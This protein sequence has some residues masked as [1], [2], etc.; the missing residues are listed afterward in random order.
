MQSAVLAGVSGNLYRLL[1]EY[2]VT[3]RRSR[4]LGSVFLLEID[5]ALREMSTHLEEL[6]FEDAV[7][8]HLHS[9]TQV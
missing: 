1:A 4:A 8:V 9:G 2:R 3:E 5:Q 7:R 6:D